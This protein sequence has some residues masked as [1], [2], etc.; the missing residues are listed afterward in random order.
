M[1]YGIPGMRWGVRKQSD[2]LTRNI[3][4]AISINDKNISGLRAFAD[5]KGKKVKSERSKILQSRRLARIRYLEQLN[6]ER[7]ARNPEAVAYLNGPEKKNRER[8]GGAILN[9]LARYAAI[10]AG[11]NI[12]ARYLT[13]KAL[14]NGL[15]G[16]NFKKYAGA[17]AALA[18]A[19]LGAHTVNAVSTYKKYK[20][21]KYGY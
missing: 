17:S 7:K 11:A 21:A 16:D 1:H 20:K 4:R 13:N 15:K 12:A 18:I 10:S 14:K 3:A 9:G 19:N 5:K 8:A 6:N 2:R